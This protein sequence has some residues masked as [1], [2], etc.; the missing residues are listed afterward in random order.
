MIHSS[1]PFAELTRLQNELNRIFSSLLENSGSAEAPFGG[2]DPPMDIVDTPTS[3]RIFLELPG[4]PRETLSVTSRGD[5]VTVSGT[6]VPPSGAPEP[7]RRFHCLERTFGT[8][9]KTIHINHP[10]NTHQG[11]ASL[12][13]GVLR[14]EFP[15]VPD[16]RS[17]EVAIPVTAGEP[18]DPPR[19]S[20]APN[21]R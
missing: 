11:T 1:G 4:V 2:W 18:A 10:V 5:A 3:I 7:E 16:L 13:A 9:S 15:K 12:A 17:R 8:F 14:L 20:G 6:K 19:P 21:P